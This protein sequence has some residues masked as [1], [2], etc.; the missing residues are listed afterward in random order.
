M[1]SDILDVSEI[2]W[3]RPSYERLYLMTADFQDIKVRQNI[4]NHRLDM[5]DEHT[6]KRIKLRLFNKT[7]NG[8]YSAYCH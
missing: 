6:I 2:F 5:I 8:D 4:L 7:R 1:H 3:R